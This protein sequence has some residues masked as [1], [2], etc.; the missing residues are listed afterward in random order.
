MDMTDQMPDDLLERILIE[1]IDDDWDVRAAKVRAYF[2][3]E[4]AN[5][6]AEV[7]RLKKI[8]SIERTCAEGEE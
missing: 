5:L 7:E 6:T 8:I 3:E 4:I 1:S 2:A